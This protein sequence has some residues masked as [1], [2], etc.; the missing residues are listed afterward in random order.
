MRS[1]ESHNR[2]SKAL[3]WGACLGI[4]FGGTSVVLSVIGY[5]G[6]AAWVAWAA[7]VAVLLP[8]AFFGGRRRAEFERDWVNTDFGRSAYEAAKLSASA[9]RRRK[10]RRDVQ[11]AHGRLTELGRR[12]PS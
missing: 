12:K 5:D 1:L 6:R 8:T 2:W 3:V 11:K 4:V 7:T 9:E 10:A